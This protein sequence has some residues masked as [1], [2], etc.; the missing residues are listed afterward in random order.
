MSKILSVASY[1]P[2]KVLTNDDLSKM[3]DTNDE[4]IVQRTGIKRRHV[5]SDG[6]T[7][8]DI[9]TRA[10][11]EALDKS[12]LNK[13]D[14][15]AI[16]FATITPDLFT[17]SMACQL[18][19]RLDIDRKNLLA[20]DINAACSGFVVAMETAHHLLHSYKNI[21]VVA[22]DTMS[23]IIDWTDRGTCILFGDGAGAVVLT[24]SEHTPKFHSFSEHDITDS[25][26]TNSIYEDKTTLSMKGTDVFKFAVNALT[27]CI[28]KELEDNNMTIE[29]VDYIVAHQANVR[30][31]SL[32]SKQLGIR[33]DKF[34]MN[35]QEY[36]NTSSASV[37]LVLAEMV[38]K[39][40]IHQGQNV[41]FVAF[42]SGLTYSSCL[43]KIEGEIK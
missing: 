12:G 16:L 39:K 33:E 13:E 14:I 29:Q 28:R 30:I 21:L 31:I 26:K 10:A 24:Q 40:M 8:L 7:N 9:A 36:G 23:R 3:V 17:P 18:K 4:W 41:L 37:P 25:L 22:S 5:V 15:D 19:R 32:A 35:I 43:W 34:Y 1:A 42:G 11:Q 20:F 27:T 6:E 2:H 38:E